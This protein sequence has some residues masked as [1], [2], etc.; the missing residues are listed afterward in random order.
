MRF[1]TFIHLH[2]GKRALARSDPHIVSSLDTQAKSNLQPVPDAL[3]GAE[4]FSTNPW[5][6]CTETGSVNLSIQ[7]LFLLASTAFSWFN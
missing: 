2:V 5:E 7:G 1:S 4:N 6:N 3:Q